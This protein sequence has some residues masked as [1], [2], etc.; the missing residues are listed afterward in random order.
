MVQATGVVVRATALP[1][2][3]FDVVE[4]VRL[5]D[6]VVQL[7]LA[8]PDLTA[9]GPAFGDLTATYADVRVAVADQE[10]VPVTGLLTAL[11]VPLPAPAT[12]L[13]VRYRVSGVAV[14][15][16]P[17]PD[18]RA[19]GA[20]APLVDVDAVVGFE[21]D[22]PAVRTVTCPMLPARADA[23]RGRAAAPVSSSTPSR[24]PTRWCSPSWT[25]GPDD[26]G[27]GPSWTPSTGSWPGW[28]TRASAVRSRSWSCS[29]PRGCG[30][31][32]WPWSPSPGRP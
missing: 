6:P 17:S 32:A 16:V 4:T 13:E 11:S 26:R 3:S 2:G 24:S 25:W 28:A 15:T 31:V 19:L 12:V 22:G 29:G 27:H 5:S 8:V 20:L 18:G 10:E 30:S 21:V 23:V 9:A 14:R 7:R 1:D